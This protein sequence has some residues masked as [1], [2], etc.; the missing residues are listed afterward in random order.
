MLIILTLYIVLVWL[1][2]WELKLVK[3]GW[4]SGAIAVLVG[5][6]AQ[7]QVDQL[8]A[9]YEQATANVEGLAKQLGFHGQRQLQSAK[10]AQLNAKLAMDSEISGVNTTVAQIQAQLADAKWDLE[11]TTVRA[12]ADGIVTLMALTVGDRALQALLTQP[13]A[14]LTH[15]SGDLP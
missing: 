15:Q 7:Q 10:A 14:R 12:P 3:W 6:D 9:K 2:F 1:L 8:K 13:R 5:A 4:V 11:Q